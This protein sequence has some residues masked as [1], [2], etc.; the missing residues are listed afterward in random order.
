MLDYSCLNPDSGANMTGDQ[1][2]S[3]DKK[4]S[5]MKFLQKINAARIWILLQGNKRSERENSNCRPVLGKQKNLCGKLR[6]LSKT[7]DLLNG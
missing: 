4:N 3:H 7:P 6:C 5:H 2:Q 1:Y